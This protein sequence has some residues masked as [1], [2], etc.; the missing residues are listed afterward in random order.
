MGMRIEMNV[1]ASGS[2]HMSGD[3]SANEFGSVFVTVLK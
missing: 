1:N 2:V 3:L